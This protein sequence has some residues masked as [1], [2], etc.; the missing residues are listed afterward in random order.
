MKLKLQFVSLL[1]AAFAAT[2]LNAATPIY[3]DS[4]KDVESRVSDLLK[5]MTLEEKIGQLNQRSAW[6]GPDGVTHF[7]QE[8]A[9]GRIGSI[10][11]LVNASDIDA[12]QHAAMEK[13]RLGIPVLVSRDVIH[14]YKTIFPIPLG[15]AATFDPELVSKG[16]RISAIE[17]SSDGVRWTFAPMIDIARD[18]RWGRIAESCGE[19]VY[20][21]TIMARA[22]V[23]GFQGKN[24][25][26]PTAVAAC[27]KHFVG[28]GAS[29]SGRDYNSTNIPERQLRNVYLP[30]FEEAC[31]AG[32]LTYMSSFND[33][34]GV[35]SSGNK[36]IL[37]DVLRDE[38]GF[39]GFVVSDWASVTEMINHGFCADRK[40][41]AMKGFNAGVD[42]EM[43][44]ASYIENL[45]T[46]IDEGKVSMTDIDTAVANIL[47]VKF[48]L[49]LFDNPYIVTP[50]SV[51]YAPEHLAAAKQT[52]IESAILLKNDNETLPIGN[53]VKT[54]L[55]TGPLAD[56][57]YEQMGTWVF[58][59]EKEHTVTL[60]TALR[61]EYGKQANILY[62]PGLAY[63]RD[64]DSASI[65][66]AVA[67]AA[68]ADM[69][70]AAVGEEAILSGEAHSMASLDLVGAQ[71]ELISRLSATGKPVVTIVMAGRPLSIGKQVEE[72]S[73]VIYSFHPGTMG[74]E[75]LAE[76]LF[77]KVSPSGK[78][79]V[80]IP[81]SAGQEPLYYSHNNSGRP[82]NGTETLLKDIP[83]EAGQTSLGC[84][85]FWLDAGFGPLFPFGYGL[86][87]GKFEYSD[88][89][90][91]KECYTE[92]ENIK[93]SFTLTNSGSHEATEV[94]QLYVRD[95]VGSVTRPVKELKGFQRVTLAAGESRHMSF[96]LP[97]S[98]LAFYGLDMQKRVEP[99]E[100]TLWVG[101]D[102]N[103]SLSKLFN[104]KQNK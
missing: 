14:G 3:K 18:A 63:S 50:Q 71:G 31:K 10:L 47:R 43:E 22:M 36:F 20:L 87:Y 74:G 100:F 6:G 104:V 70:I 23:E 54:I 49:G 80:S 72:S 66:R 101:G 53:N 4:R 55:V 60:L 90:L 11:N 84:T 68:N 89:S 7:S 58:D 91:D 27:A 8:A 88:L 19:D 41:A 17:A 77:G 56:A 96:T 75:A 46:L 37:K 73:A 28:Y 62:E 24:L 32:C 67:A 21:S 44:S 76:I 83:V 103:C 69:V 13:S 59:G 33:N 45:Q 35:P 64:T 78:T 98:D 99:G 82:A 81:V 48:M 97:V 93:V 40:D 79:P 102:S 92:D 26:D 61:N 85:S 39:R 30:P 94:A 12:I 95:M 57:P 9:A 42:M 1:C 15:Q 29:E 52:A 5:R 25:T 65:D 38:W 2:T 16:A 86:S 34:D 51:K